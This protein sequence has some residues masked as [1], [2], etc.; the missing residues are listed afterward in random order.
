[1]RCDGS[2]VLRRDVD[3]VPDTL[4]QPSNHQD[5]SRL[6]PVSHP[7]STIRLPNQPDEGRIHQSALVTLLYSRPTGPVAIPS[8]PQ[9]AARLRF[10]S[11]AAPQFA[12]PLQFS[13]A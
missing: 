3:L 1:M 10:D 11:Y 5:G 8:R 9:D 12:L 13:L 7:V 2:W 6:A 4:G